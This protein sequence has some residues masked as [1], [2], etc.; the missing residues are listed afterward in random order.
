MW[1]KG[2]ADA[3][4][5]TIIAANAAQRRAD[6]TLRL[7]PNWATKVGTITGTAGILRRT[8]GE[9]VHHARHRHAFGR[10]LADQRG[11]STAN[12]RS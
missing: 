1:D 9:A 12:L 2:F 11:K 4:V 10:A 7:T 6:V 8:L 3:Q 5:D